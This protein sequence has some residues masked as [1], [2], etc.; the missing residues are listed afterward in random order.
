MLLDGLMMP[1]NYKI[2]IKILIKACLITKKFNS[3]ILYLV[4][5]DWIGSFLICAIVS[6]LKEQIIYSHIP[7]G[8]VIMKLNYK[9]R[10]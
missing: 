2:Y 5:D 9:T 3:I 1:D 4:F 7:T 6:L 8:V 10:S